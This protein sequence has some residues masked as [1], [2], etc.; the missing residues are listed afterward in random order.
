ML[1]YTTDLQNSI[2]LQNWNF[3]SIKQLSILPCPKFQVTM[4]LPSGSMNLTIL[5][6]ILYIS[7]IIQ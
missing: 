6:W 2:H 4:N 3:V 5:L 7:V 1:S